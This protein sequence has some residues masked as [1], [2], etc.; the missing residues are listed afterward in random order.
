MSGSWEP[1]GRT[2]APDTAPA[3]RRRARSRLAAAAPA[4]ALDRR[5]RRA[6]AVLT[7]MDSRLD[8]LRDLGL[9]RG[10]AMVLRNAGATLSDDMERSLR[11][12]QE[13]LGI[14]EVWLVGHTD[15]AAHGGDLGAVRAT[16]RDGV[17]RDRR[18]AARVQRADAAL[19]PGDG[20][21]RARRLTASRAIAPATIAAPPATASATAGP[22]T[23]SRRLVRLAVEAGVVGDG[24]VGEQR[25]ADRGHARAGRARPRRAASGP[26]TAPNVMTA[27]ASAITSS[28]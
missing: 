4:A 23:A 15:C 16:L 9:A 10:D 17:R 14:H 3:G 26:A 11:I 24:P 2:T 28:A 21:R 12:A 20:S 7:C 22:A 25:D 6:L 18:R 1:F 19:R 13:D 8:P 5:P 27:A